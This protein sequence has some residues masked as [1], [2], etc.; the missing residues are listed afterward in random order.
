MLLGIFA[1]SA[2]AVAGREVSSNLDTFELML[3]RSLLGV[4]VVWALA[5]WRGEALKTERLPLHLLRNVFHFT[6]QNLW[7]YAL[8]L[9]PLAQVFALEFTTPIWV[10]LLAPLALREPLTRVGLIAVLLGFLGILVIVR[11][12]LVP[13][14]FAHGA[15]LLSALGFAGTVLSTKLLSGTENTFRVLFYMTLMQSGLALLCAAPGGHC[16]ASSSEP[17]LDSRVGALRYWCPLLH[18]ASPAPGAGKYRFAA[19]LC[20][21]APYRR[22]G[23]APLRRAHRMGGVCRGGADRGGESAE[24][25]WPGFR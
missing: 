8:A 12:G 10:V 11:P 20:P 21:P 23:D 7:F 24:Y 5:R 17:P 6:A 2:V 4:P 15:T 3:Y 9:I 18:H 14:E 16:L 1:L 19:G 13:L 25:S 22:G